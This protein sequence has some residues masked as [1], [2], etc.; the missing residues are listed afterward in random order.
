VCGVGRKDGMKGYLEKI[1]WPPVVGVLA[2]Y[3]FGLVFIWG[4][5][6]V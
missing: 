2:V 1:N 4:E 6:R 5:S 3:K